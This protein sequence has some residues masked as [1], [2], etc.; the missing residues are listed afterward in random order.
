[1]EGMLTVIVTSTYKPHPGK[2]RL[3][4]SN[5]KE[6]VESFGAMGMTCRISRVI[7][8][9]DTGSLVFSF[10]L[11][12]LVELWGMQKRFFQAKYGLKFKCV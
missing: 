11:K 4:L 5:M 10:F 2:A 7:F 3:V 9:P 8:G 1:M 12:T 6:N